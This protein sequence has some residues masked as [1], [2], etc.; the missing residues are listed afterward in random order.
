MILRQQGNTR[1]HVNV[2]IRLLDPD[3]GIHKYRVS[4][5]DPG[6]FIGPE[7]VEFTPSDTVPLK[8]LLAL[9]P[10]NC[11]IFKL[12][13]IAPSKLLPTGAKDLPRGI[14]VWCLKTINCPSRIL[15]SPKTKLLELEVERLPPAQVFEV[16]NLSHVTIHM[17]RQRYW[18]VQLVPAMKSLDF[19]EAV[20][21]TMVIHRLELMYLY[22]LDQLVKCGLASSSSPATP[23]SIF[24]TKGLYD[25]RLLL[26]ITA[27]LLPQT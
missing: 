13:V 11:W 4:W 22:Y 2:V 26:H 5:D 21:Q 15:F 6:W 27:F 12:T 3:S 14:V 1:R 10:R 25:P 19:V 23:W 24:L 18:P 7:T 16:D 8:A 17:T 20:A 9:V